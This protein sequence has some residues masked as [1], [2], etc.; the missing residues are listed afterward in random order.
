MK[1]GG[2]W[3]PER[4]FNNRNLQQS[5]SHTHV[6]VDV[7]VVG[8]AFFCVCCVFMLVFC[9]CCF[10]VGDVFFIVGVVVFVLVW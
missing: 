6:C 5:V 9:C 7:C 1:E 10:F 3:W 4:V 2:L 8:V